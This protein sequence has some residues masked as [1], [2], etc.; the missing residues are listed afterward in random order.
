MLNLLD[1]RSLSDLTK[2]INDEAIAQA[3]V[4]L[5]WPLDGRWYLLWWT[6]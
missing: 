5:V 3:D 6:P 4:Q 1:F 2:Y